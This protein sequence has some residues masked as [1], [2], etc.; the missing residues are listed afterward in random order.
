MRLNSHKINKMKNNILQK[1]Q[2]EKD[3]LKKL[4]QKIKNIIDT[5]TKYTF[6]A[7]IIRWIPLKIKI[8]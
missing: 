4:S 6:Y 1:L 2:L 7:D 3:K 8:K 5:V